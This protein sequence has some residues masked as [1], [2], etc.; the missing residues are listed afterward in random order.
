MAFVHGKGAVFKLDNAADVLTD[1]SAYVRSVSPK[2]SAD[3]AE[4]TCFGALVKSYIAGLTDMTISVEGVW[5][6]TLD[7]ILHA[8][9]GATK[10]FEFGPEGSTGGDIKYTAECICTSYTP[11]DASVDGAVMWSADLQVTGTLT[12]TTY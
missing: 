1:I 12:R 11:G 10:T 2:R 7:A 6:A 5:D 9:L 8:A 4:V 3:T